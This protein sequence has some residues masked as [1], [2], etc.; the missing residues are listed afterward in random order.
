MV[1]FTKKKP[2]NQVKL[3]IHQGNVKVVVSGGQNY[4]AEAYFDFTLQRS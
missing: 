3:Y 4:Y 1:I 2:T